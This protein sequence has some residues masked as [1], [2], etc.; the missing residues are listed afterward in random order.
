MQWRITQIG[1]HRS[2]P[3]I[4]PWHRSHIRKFP[5]LHHGLTAVISLAQ[6]E[7]THRIPPLSPGLSAVSS[8]AQPESHAG[9]YSKVTSAVRSPWCGL[10]DS[11]STGPQSGGLDWLA[12]R[13]PPAAVSSVRRLICKVAVSQARR[14]KIPAGKSRPEACR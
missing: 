1:V 6:P 9:A 12:P 7:S 2:A 11:S 3:A 8:L 4:T 5:P 10:V 13:T 14:R